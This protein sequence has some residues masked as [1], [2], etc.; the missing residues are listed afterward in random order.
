MLVAAQL[1]HVPPQHDPAQAV[2][3]DVD[4]LGPAGASYHLD[5]PA[6]LSGERAHAVAQGVVVDGI[7]V[8]EA[9]VAKMPLDHV[10][11]RAVVPVAVDEED[12]GLVD[13]SVYVAAGPGGDEGSVEEPEG[14][15]GHARGQRHGFPQV[16]DICG[17]P[18]ECSGDDAH[19]IFHERD[20][21]LSTGPFSCFSAPPAPPLRAIYENDVGE[22]ARYAE[23]FGHCPRVAQPRGGYPGCSR[24]VRFAAAGGLVESLTESID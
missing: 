9:G 21:R 4:T 10:P 19:N 11:G 20:P 8:G 16:T 23:G 1:L 22:L 2:A 15:T 24:I 12:R 3:D 7:D 5:P 18:S 6:Q 17:R 14:V 13:G